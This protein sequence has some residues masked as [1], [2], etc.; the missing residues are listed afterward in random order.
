LALP[1]GSVRVVDLFATGGPGPLVEA[2]SKIEVVGHN[3][4]F[5]LG[6]LRHHFGIAPRACW[7]SMLASQL[8]SGVEQPNGQRHPK[9]YHSLE[10]V[11]ERALGVKLDKTMQKSDWSGLLTGEQ[12]AYAA[13]DVAHLFP[14]REAL[15]R[16]LQVRSLGAVMQIENALLPAMV[17]LRLA[18]VPVNLMALDALAEERARVSVE[19][20]QRVEAALHIANANSAV[21][22]LLP[23]LRALGFK[24]TATNAEAL[25]PYQDHP[26]V[27]DL[28]AMRTEKK[29]ADDARELA[30]M[31]RAQPDGRV[32]PDWR[33]IGAPTGRMSTSDP[34]MLGLPKDPGMRACIAAPPGRTFI[35][36]DYAAIELRVLA[37]VTGDKRLTAI[38]RAGGDPHRAL[39]AILLN[40]P[41]TDVTSDE[42]KRAK[43]VNFGFCFGMGVDRF[44]AYALKDYGVVFTPAEARG[45][46]GS[47]LS[48][49]REVDAWQ[50]R[51]RARMEREVRTVAGRVRNFASAHDGYTDRL[52]MP[53]QGTAADGMKRAMALL[54]PRLARHDAQIILAVHD[55]LVVEAPEAAAEEVKAIVVAG[56]IEGMAVDVT[57]VPIVV[58]AEVRRTWGKP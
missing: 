40:K 8:V 37:H 5:D 31:A 10:A 4:G 48:A 12:I 26:V 56:M 30:A 41:P 54:A 33:Q 36:A 17:G 47:Y 2:L 18:G 14:L 23:A 22:Q 52:N 55:E 11:L 9:G 13:D 32:R 45:F 49:Y 16:G 53:I 1:D 58:E 21:K 20:K 42:R 6:F 24:V 35:I 29:T 43:P 15:E 3:L 50:Q 28:Q 19:A 51:T 39:A 46:K 7:D 34:N 57:S 38:F 27:R 25:A 44:V